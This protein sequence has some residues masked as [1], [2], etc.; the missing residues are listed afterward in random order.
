VYDY[1]HYNHVKVTPKGWEVLRDRRTVTLTRPKRIER[2]KREI[3]EAVDLPAMNKSLFEELRQLRRNIAEEQSVPPYVIFNDY[4]LKEI[5]ARL[6]MDG[7]EFLAISGVG[8]VKA[9]Q[10]GMQFLSVVRTFL[11]ENP[12]IAKPKEV[13]YFSQSNPA[14]SNHPE[15]PRP[16]RQVIISD[17]AFETLRF[18]QKG[19]SPA[20]IA[21]IRGF[22]ASTINSQIAD[23]IR[24][25]HIKSLDL[26]VE[27]SKLALIRE[28]FK[29]HGFETITAAKEHLGDA[30]SFEELRFVRAFDEGKHESR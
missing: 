19:Y 30:Y 5:A 8:E 27:P 2:E 13:R 25:G 28:A 12:S 18:F 21:G 16:P 17:S 9:R 11:K 3:R 22:A 29:K 15:G 10:Y 6:P 24:S 1:D 4:T 23:L 7:Q 20:K 14:V 26:L